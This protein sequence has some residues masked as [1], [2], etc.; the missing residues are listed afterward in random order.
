MLFARFFARK[1]SRLRFT[2]DLP[3]AERTQLS[4]E[5]NACANRQGGSLKNAR[6]AQALTSLFAGLSPAGKMV[7]TEVLTDLNDRMQ[8]APGDRYAEIE[9]AELFGGSDSKLA[10]LDMFETPR[11][12]VLSHL[13]ETENGH[14]ILAE[15]EALAG[16]EVRAEIEELRGLSD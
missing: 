6:R 8:R 15:I 11:R 14:G 5:L 13:K 3:G 9:E 2:P 16:P 1:D 10:V 4:A 12:R 7:F